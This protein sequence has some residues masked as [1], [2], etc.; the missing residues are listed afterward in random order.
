MTVVHRLSAILA[1][2]ATAATATDTERAPYGSTYAPREAPPLVITGATVITGTSTP[3]ARTSIR[4]ANGRITAIGADVPILDGD[5]TVDGTDMF[6]TPGIID[7]HSHLGDYPSPSIASTQDVN[8]M[9]DPNTAGVWAEHSVWTQDPQFPLAL[10]GGVTTL[11]VL[12]GSANLFGGRGVTL[13]NVP[14]V[15]VQAM[16]FPDAP[17]SLKMACGENPK[18]VYGA[19]NQAPG[20]RMGNVAG[21]RNAWARATRYQSKVQ[22]AEDDAEK[23]PPEPDLAMDTLAGVLR[24]EI[25]VQNHCYRAEEMAVMIDVAREFGYRITT[26]HHAIESYKIADLLAAEGICSA[27]WA[28]WWGFKLEAFDGIQQ[29]IAI[30]E[31]AGACA[32]V[33]SD[34]ERGVQRLNQEAAKALAAG[35]RAGIELSEE[36]ALAWVTLNA[37]KAIGIDAET[38]SIEVG[39][40]ADLVL[41]DGHPLSVYSRPSRVY[42][43]GYLYYDANDPARQPTTDFELLTTPSGFRRADPADAQ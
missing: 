38:G 5:R 34:S 26:F 7:V 6:L 41:W 18:R 16:K 24:G 19:R 17:Q 22:M 30:L 31:S 23:E 1:L 12:P 43:D 2:W 40:A 42:I 14:A 15:T 29:N 32:V 9:T 11:H 25:L 33:H 20:T 37:A 39:K 3:S 35:R 36:Q 8:E 27:T 10:A 13:K 21:Y 4:V 28:D